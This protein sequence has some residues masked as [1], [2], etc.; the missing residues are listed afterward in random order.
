VEHDE[1]G[2]CEI[3]RQIGRQSFQRLDAAGGCADDDDAAVPGP[4]GFP[5]DG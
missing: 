2:G 5:S 4:D 3:G 1:D